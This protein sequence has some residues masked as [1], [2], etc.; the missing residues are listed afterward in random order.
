[1]NY[2]FRMAR[3]I[4]HAKGTRVVAGNQDVTILTEVAPGELCLK[5]YLEAL[6]GG[7]TCGGRTPPSVVGVE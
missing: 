5:S 1:M 3:G 7:L 4:P 6:P 2:G